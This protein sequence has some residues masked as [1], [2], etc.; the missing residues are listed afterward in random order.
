MADPS[1]AQDVL[2]IAPLYQNSEPGRQPFE[3]TPLSPMP[4]A[5]RRAAGIPNPAAQSFGG[6]QLR[7]A[8]PCPVLDGRF[9]IP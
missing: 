7:H 3:G 1:A 9:V 6:L 5:G 2:L 8:P 4:F